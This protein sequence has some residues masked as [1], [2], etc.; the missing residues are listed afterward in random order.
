MDMFVTTFVKTLI[1]I[2][3]LAHASPTQPPPPP[4]DRAA[5]VCSAL[6]SAFML[7][8]DAAFDE[9]MHTVG[10]GRYDADD[11]GDLAKA[12]VNVQHPATGATGSG[13]GEGSILIPFLA[14]F[15]SGARAFL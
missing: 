14:T 12:L 4:A 11:D 13:L 1:F 2:N 15:Q 8:T 3:C 9:L 5:R 10:L 6:E 7:D